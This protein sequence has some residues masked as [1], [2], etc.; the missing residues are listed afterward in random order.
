MKKIENKTICVGL[1]NFMDKIGYQ[2]DVYKK[3]GEQ[4]RYLVIDTT[5]TSH[6]FST[7]YKADVVILRKTTIIRFFQTIKEIIIYRPNAIEIY[8]SALPK[9]WDHILAPLCKLLRIR[10]IL[11]LR[12][13]EFVSSYRIHRLKVLYPYMDLIISK[14]LHLTTKA[15]Q[16]GFLSKLECLHNGVPIKKCRILDYSERKIDILFLNSPR[17]ERNIL[18]LIEVFHELL[19]KT[20]IKLNIVMASFGILDNKNYKVEPRYQKKIINKIRELGLE[21]DIKIL[22]FVDNAEELLK[23]SKIFIF[24]ANVVFCNYALLE[25][26]SLGCVPIVTNGEGAYWIINDLNG[27][28]SKLEVNCFIDAINEALNIKTWRKK[29][30][31]SILTVEKYFSIDDWYT[32]IKKIK[33]KHFI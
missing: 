2:S 6:F 26:M 12:G 18:F 27:F 9:F 28:V 7:K 5:G 11:F 14:E 29:S 24:P 33:A 17:K 32:G 19:K 1:D 10:L 23:Q 22:G 25:A 31:Q 21:N 13:T 30:E 20:N 16:L 8:L 4:I 15:I 3:N